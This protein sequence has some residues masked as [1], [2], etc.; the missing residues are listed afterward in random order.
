M[1]GFQEILIITAI[2]LGLIFLPR[3]ITRRLPEKVNRPEFRLSGKIRIA[4]AAS[5]IYPALVAAYL[6]PWQ[7]DQV[8]FFY[9]G[10]GP[11]ALGWL[12]GWV[13]VGFNKK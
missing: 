10:I 3:M 6:H 2:I 7:K 1:F 8:L 5:A 11:V 12:I 13:F 4:I 9:M